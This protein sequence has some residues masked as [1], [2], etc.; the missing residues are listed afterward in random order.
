MNQIAI[1]FD[2]Q[3]PPATS[4]PDK[5]TILDV[6]RCKRDLFRADFPAWLADNFHIWK[7]FERE[8]D[9]VWARGRTRYSGRTII[10]VLRHESALRERESEW[11]LNDWWTPDLCRLYMLMWPERKL[12]ELRGRH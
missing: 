12:F 8:A 4:D 6:I 7:A 10:E 11:K 9:K 2:A 3:R 1:D 5:P